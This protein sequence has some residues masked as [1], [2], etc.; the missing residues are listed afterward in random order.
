[1]KHV[2]PILFL[3][4]L[5]SFLRP[6]WAK[7]QSVSNPPPNILQS[8][9]EF[10]QV[11]GY[12]ESQL[13]TSDTGEGGGR[14]KLGEF[15]AFWTPRI[16]ETDS[17]GYN[18]FTRYM[19]AALL[20]AKQKQVVECATGNYNGSW[21]CI[22]P[23]HY[24][25]QQKMGYIEEV[26]ADPA[27]AAG[28]TVLAATNGGLFKTS[29]GG[30]TWECLTDNSTN[31]IN[32]NH[33]TAITVHPQHKDT[34]Y[35]GTYNAWIYLDRVYY[36][37][38]PVFG[39]GM[40]YTTD[41][42]QT[43]SQEFIPQKPNAPF[44]SD[45]VTAI[46]HVTFSPD[47]N[48]LYA[49]RGDSVFWRAYPTGTWQ[50][51]TPSGTTGSW[52]D[53]YFRPGS[54]NFVLT[55][56]T[57]GGDVSATSRGRIVYC[58]V[59]SNTHSYTDLA[60]AINIPAPNSGAPLTGDSLSDT[61][62][63]F[64]D[65]TRLLCAV[66]LNAD[67]NATQWGGG[68][69]WK[70][71][72]Y[73][74][75]T[76][77]W[78]FIRFFGSTLFGY[79]D[80]NWGCQACFGFE[81]S[82]AD[83]NRVYFRG[84]YPYISLDGGQTLHARI[85]E[86]GGS[87]THGDVRDIFIHT[88]SA[89][90]SGTNDIVLLATDGGVSIKRANRNPVALGDTA[91]EN[92]SQNGPPAHQ[93]YSI[94]TS[95]Q[96][97]IKLAGSHHNGFHAHEPFLLPEWKE[98]GGGDT[99]NGYFERT[100]REKGVVQSSLFTEEISQTVENNGRVLDGLANSP[101]LPN[102][103]RF[104][105]VPFAVD[106]SNHHFAGMVRFVIRTGPDENWIS[107]SPISNGL[108]A[109]DN[110]KIIAM[111]FVPTS[112]A[113]TDLVG[114]VAYENNRLYYRNPAAGLFLPNAFNQL[115]YPDSARSGITDITLDHQD[116]QRVWLSRRSIQWH[117]TAKNR[118]IYS[119]NGGTAWRDISKGLPVHIPV[120]SIVYQQASPY[121]YAS[122]DVG[123]Y[124][125]DL[126]G[127]APND[128]STDGINQSVQWTCFSEGASGH[129]DF[130]NVIVTDL[131]INYCAGVLLASTLGRSIWETPLWD[132]DTYN[133]S[134]IATITTNTTWNSTKY[135][136]G[137]VVVKSGSTLTITTPNNSAQTVV[138][139]PSESYIHV[140]PG[141]KLVVTNAR[142]TNACKDCFWKGIEAA[143]KSWTTIGENN[144]RAQTPQNVGTV[145]INGGSIIEHARN[146]V[147]NY[148]EVAGNTDSVGGIIQVSGAHFRNNRRS[149]CWIKYEAHVP[150][151]TYFEPASDKSWVDQSTFDI[152]DNWRGYANAEIFGAHISMDRVYGITITGNTF[153]NHSTTG[154]NKGSGNG[155]H[156][157][158]AQY[159]VV[160][161]CSAPA[162]AYPGTCPAA[163]VIPNRFTN[164][165]NGIYATGIMDFGFSGIGVDSAIF[166]STAVGVYFDGANLGSV[167]RSNFT[168][169]NAF[170]VCGPSCNQN[171][172]IYAKNAVFSRIEENSFDGDGGHEKLGV[173][174]E[175][176]GVS[177]KIIYKNSFS[178]LDYGCFAEGANAYWE[179]SIKNYGLRVL[180]NSFSGNDTDIVAYEG[181]P[182]PGPYYDA[183]YHYAGYPTISM[184]NTFP[185]NGG[186][187]RY[188]GYPNHT[189]WHHGGTSAPA[190]ATG[191]VLAYNSG[192]PACA[193]FIP[194][195]S[196]GGIDPVKISGEDLLTLG[197]GMRITAA[198]AVTAEVAYEG[199]LDGGNTAGLL[200]LVAF[201]TSSSY[202]DLMS[203][204]ERIAPYCSRTVLQAVV[205]ADILALEHLMSVLTAHPEVLR[206]PGFMQYLEE[207]LPQDFPTDAME[208]LWDATST[209]TGRATDEAAIQGY[210]AEES[211]S[212]NQLTADL[213]FDTSLV[214]MDS[215]IAWY[216]A[217][218]AL[219][220]KFAKAAYQSS[221]GLYNAADS[222]YDAIQTDFELTTSET[223]ERIA[224]MTIDALLREMKAVDSPITS[225]SPYQLATLQGLVGS[226]YGAAA[227]TAKNLIS[228][229]TSNFGRACI[230]GLDITLNP[231][232]RRKRNGQPNEGFQRP[233][234]ANRVNASPNPA[235]DVVTFEY[236]LPVHK[237]SVSL[238]V[239][240]VSGRRIQ[241]IEV[242]GNEGRVDW[243][244]SKVAP[245]TYLYSINDQVRGLAEGKIV[246]QR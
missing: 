37:G 89:T 54:N 49:I 112:Q 66:T 167:L 137:S 2:Y 86:Y 246:V 143:G 23:L 197:D 223:Q 146:G 105:V 55:S 151:S 191:F 48:K 219:W 212:F 209:S 26:W 5:I 195:P 211:I 113:L 142:L 185:Q 138:H 85:G 234:T 79:G 170:Q 98:I 110:T 3:L 71:L 176:V 104:D 20:D 163:D 51:I 47:G 196:S 88:N 154:A 106:D 36:G 91:S 10:N 101:D 80:F 103:G 9:V 93:L 242:K 148:A 96:G 57:D 189:Y 244:V 35:L 30:A 44:F 4:V 119:T 230:T 102:I 128:T 132:Y 84:E 117:E 122:T 205:E 233:A 19:H 153:N 168:V 198:A 97:N 18:M 27:D 120:T 61:R 15:E 17:S 141:G 213:A 229:A 99:W 217:T 124:R 60:S 50:N 188:Y 173:V 12:L 82:A 193:S 165:T 174:A 235:S 162:V 131:E 237:G 130:P 181:V 92:M 13:S 1:M 216:D 107:T 203:E 225:M 220:A 46:S 70:L 33:I 7:A 53:I 16:S 202:G 90:D 64:R 129:P 161:A 201:S 56:F 25:D 34:I 116:P 62:A 145:I 28:N 208:A 210:R 118:V 40:L 29:N 169:G 127:Y 182:S 100:D 59:S 72:E 43:W 179:T 204:L 228:V 241:R 222:T 114:Y 158:A 83:P 22:G 190:S 227:R 108:I 231:M 171:I 183:L 177:N 238:M 32:A 38:N 109:T 45:S 147:C 11:I 187:I 186:V 87:P 150:N 115:T 240:D 159:K 207:E 200:G 65:G 178:D 199:A 245:G 68:G 73:N 155:I 224:F 164:L 31:F 121:V 184:G 6:G 166:D 123:I 74:F 111:E 215:L 221:R 58:T 42:G 157:F 160:P 39:A 140:E 14:T 144:P 69:Q 239:T 81:V 218:P 192:A 214:R 243:N 63:V 156:S 41:G 52:G 175:N 24:P 75:S 134:P 232:L 67:V 136:T 135:L 126:T 206:E 77:S 172:G 76:S 95:E 139:M 149:L 94:A 226:E 125:C 78:S 194:P 133:P 180:C 236:Y 21:K 152:D 8:G